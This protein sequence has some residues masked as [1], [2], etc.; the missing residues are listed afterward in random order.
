[1]KRRDFMI[2][3]AAMMGVPMAGAEDK[4]VCQVLDTDHIKDHPNI[5]H[6]TIMRPGDYCLDRDWSQ[7]KLGWFGHYGTGDSDMLRIY[8]G[9]V[10]VDMQG[11]SLACNYERTGVSLSAGLNREFA[12]R[13]SQSARQPLIRFSNDSLD[14][15]FV[16]LR[17]GI[18]DLTGGEKTWTG[19][20]FNDAWGHEH[21]SNPFAPLRPRL[22]SP[23][24]YTRNEYLLDNLKI[25]TL[26]IGVL[27]EGTHNVIR[28]CVI[29]A[30][31]QAALACCGP[32][33]TIENCEIWLKPSAGIKHVSTKLPR[34]AIHLRDGSR[35]VIRNNIIRVSPS[36]DDKPSAILIRDGAR[37]VLIENNTFINVSGDPV[38][39]A[40]NSE[41][42]VRNN[43][44]QQRW[45][46]W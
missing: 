11:H 6:L 35:A 32:D 26:D 30:E 14:N 24:T 38:A 3:M 42:I 40:E 43:K 44:T 19:I 17:N 31:G 33:V 36:E 7:K 22:A 46:P 5:V 13:G 28:N 18:I 45:I 23:D 8:C 4:Q 37:D 25:Y 39:L 1:M 27:L 21:F 29:H 41:A 16:T 12:R 15:R 9:Q 20:N 34:A 10:S 2:G